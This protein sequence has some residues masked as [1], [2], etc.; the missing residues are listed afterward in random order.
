MSIIPALFG[1]EQAADQMIEIYQPSAA[2]PYRSL[3]GHGYA[4][5]EHLVD[6]AAQVVRAGLTPLH[7]LAGPL[8][9]R[10]CGN[11][12]EFETASLPEPPQLTH[13][14][15]VPGVP[16]VAVP[17]EPEHPDW[18]TRAAICRVED[19]HCSAPYPASPV[20]ASTIVRLWL[21]QPTA[22][23]AYPAVVLEITDQGGDRPVEYPFRV[24]QARM[25]GE[26]IRL[27]L[28]LIGA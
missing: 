20:G 2:D 3:V 7:M 14:I 11:S 9:R 27:V 8:G 13:H 24:H 4:C 10:H 6:L 22:R 21:E 1:C 16:P 17:V 23:P 12:Y 19:I 15:P 5:R 25:L 18:C 26:Q 28:A